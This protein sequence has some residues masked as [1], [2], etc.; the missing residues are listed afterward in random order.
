MISDSGFFADGKWHGMAEA[1]RGDQGEQLIGALDRSGFAGLLNS[2][3]ETF[4]EADV[5]AYWA[6]FEDGRGNRRRSSSI[7][8]WISRSSLP[9]RADSPGSAYRPCCSG[10]SA[11]RSRRSPVRSASSA[12]SRGA[13]L[14]ALDAGHFVFDEQPRRS[15]EEVVGFL[16]QPVG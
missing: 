8:R 16:A 5:D 11:T 9:I 1:L 4:D 15:I 13:R 10:A 2:G 6:P 3:G 14:V 12:R 7:A